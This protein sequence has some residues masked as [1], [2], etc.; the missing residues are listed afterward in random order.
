MVR[1]VIKMSRVEM[2]AFFICPGS[3]CIPCA[4]GEVFMTVEGL[5]CSKKV[6]QSLAC[7]QRLGRKGT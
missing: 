1:L 7:H 6:G 3:L 5:N 2:V 4:V